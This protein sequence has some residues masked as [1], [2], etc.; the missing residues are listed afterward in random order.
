MHLAPNDTMALKLFLRSSRKLSRGTF[1]P[2]VRSK[3]RVRNTFILTKPNNNHLLS[4]KSRGKS[5]QRKQ[6]KIKWH[7]K[8]AIRC[9]TINTMWETKKR[10][11][12]KPRNKVAKE[13]TSKLRKNLMP[14]EK[15]IE[16]IGSE[17]THG[18]KS[19][20]NLWY[21]YDSGCMALHSFDV[22]HYT[23]KRISNTAS[24]LGTF[25]MARWSDSI[26]INSVYF[27]K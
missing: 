25:L 17:R 23:I 15:P 18:Q 5:I 24:K 1:G 8:K 12:L 6:H 19:R 9:D 14:H 7:T 2:G 21:T 11:A 3:T 4:Q 22:T 27:H 16:S 26:Q 20:S 10:C 13:A